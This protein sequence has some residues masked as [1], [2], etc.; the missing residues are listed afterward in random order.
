M[1]DY[2]AQVTLRVCVQAQTEVERSLHHRFIIG[3]TSRTVC[4][5]NQ[6]SPVPA[7]ICE[8][9]QKAATWATPPRGP[10]NPMPRLSAWLVALRLSRHTHCLSHRKT[11][12]LSTVDYQ[13][14]SCDHVPGHH[15][16]PWY[17]PL[18]NCAWAKCQVGQVK[19]AHRR[20]LL[21]HPSRAAARMAWRND[22]GDCDAIPRSGS[23]GRAAGSVYRIQR[24][25][26]EK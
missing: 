10:S 23:M 22:L 5:I 9:D 16:N 2:A 12:R 13:F 8:C 4:A 1:T 3:N 20:R 11:P 14:P 25:Q 7:T 18:R 19:S 24:G 26:E 21:V 17:S 6:R 15:D